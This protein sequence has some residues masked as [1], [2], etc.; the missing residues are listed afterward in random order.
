M[1]GASLSGPRLSSTVSGPEEDAPFPA[2]AQAQRRGLR[3]ASPCGDPSGRAAAEA[4]RA[5]RPAP[6]PAACARC[7]APGPPLLLLPASRSPP[8]SPNRARAPH[9]PGPPPSA[10]RRQD[11]EQVARVCK[12]PG[13]GQARTGEGGRAGH[14]NRTAPCRRLLAPLA[15]GAPAQRPHR[16][17]RTV[18]GPSA[19]PATASEGR[20]H[21]SDRVLREDPGGRAVWRWP[22]ESFQPH[23]AGG[24][25]LPEGRGQGKWPGARGGERTGK[26][27]GSIWRFLETEEGD[28]EAGKGKVRQSGCLIGAPRPGPAA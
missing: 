22:H 2:P 4:S 3:C 28:R 18:A 10:P 14:G 5:P 12:R 15:A 26:A 25:P 20:R 6:P 1:G 16:A 8:R 21:E 11:A 24:D 9:G 23:P 7:C 13:G 27:R 17:L 19:A